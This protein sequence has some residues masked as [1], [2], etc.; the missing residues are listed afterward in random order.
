MGTGTGKTLT[1]L[2]RYLENPTDH[3]LIVCPQSIV[4]QWK[5]VIN[6]NM[7]GLT[8]LEYSKK[9][10]TAE[11][12]NIEIASFIKSDTKHKVI[13]VNFDIVYKLNSLKKINNNWTF[14]V[15]ESHRM[16][17]PTTKVSKALLQISPLTEW[18]VILT[19]T[20]AQGVKGGYVDYYTQLKF[21]DQYK[22]DFDSYERKYIKYSMINFGNS[23]YPVKTIT[24]YINTT[25]IENKL[26]LSCRYYKPKFREEQPFFNK[27]SI[28]KAPNYDRFVR[29]KAYKDISITSLSKKRLGLLTMT[30]GNVLG[31]DVV[32]NRHVYEDN[33]LKADWL[34]D[35]LEDTNERVILFYRYNVELDTILILCKRAKKRVGIINGKTK[36]KYAEI[37]KEWDVMVGQFQAMSESLD[38]LHKKSHIEIFYSMPDSSLLYQQAIGRIDRDGQEFT[39]VYYFL[40]MEGT[41]DDDIYKMIENKVEFTSETLNKLILAFDKDLVYNDIIEEDE[42]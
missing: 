26:A 7:S 31:Y 35:F 10:L 18:K 24:G 20:P 40:V 28:P 16:K 29:E 12:K 25:D 14:V 2:V 6:E 39:P 30:G 42:L 15:D 11:K 3:L 9:N 17:S 36:D 22:G 21:I 38:G 23:V 37:G 41:V 34:L 13:I 8:I 1:A 33:T 32:N 5:A 4:T 19:A 27:V